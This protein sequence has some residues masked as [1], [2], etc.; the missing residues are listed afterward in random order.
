[1]EKLKDDLHFIWSWFF[2]L[3]WIYEFTELKL[4]NIS[5]YC[6][7]IIII[8]VMNTIFITF[9]ALFNDLISLLA[10]LYRYKKTFVLYCILCDLHSR[11]WNKNNFHKTIVI[12]N[13]RIKV[14]AIWRPKKEILS[15]LA[16]VKDFNMN[17]RTKYRKYYGLL[18]FGIKFS[19]IVK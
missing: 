9:N 11:T 8:D 18:Y 6:C 10:P 7:W 2:C 4:L 14:N 15:Q 5:F 12:Q 19:E 13:T 16:V 17:F 3:C 1:M